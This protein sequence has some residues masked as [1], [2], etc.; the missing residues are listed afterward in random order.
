MA[1]PNKYQNGSIDST[2]KGV[3]RASPIKLMIYGSGKFCVIF[4]LRVLMEPRDKQP[5]VRCDQGARW[6]ESFHHYRSIAL[7][8]DPGHQEH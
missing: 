4:N 6:H 2:V 1:L 3:Y 5:T 8:E 7:R